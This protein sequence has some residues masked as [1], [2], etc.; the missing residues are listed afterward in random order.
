MTKLR[1]ITTAEP[2]AW[3]SALEAAGPH[4]FYHEAWYH[5]LAEERGE[6]RAELVVASADSHS[7]ALPILLRNIEPEHRGAFGPLEDATSVYGYPG[8]VGPPLDTDPAVLDRLAG[9]IRGYLVERGAVSVFSRLHPVIEQAALLRNPS[10][11]VEVGATASI[12]L[13]DS[14]EVQW[15]HIRAGHRNGINR[16]R[17][18]GFTCE[19]RGPAAIDTFIELYETTMRRLEVSSYYFFPRSH[20][21]AMLDPDRGNMELFVVTAPDGTPCA[22]G[23][24][25]LRGEIAQ[26]HLSGA[27]P[28]YRAQA[29]TVLM[30]DGARQWAAACG[31][32][33][34]HLGGGVGGATDSLYDFKA[35][36]GSGRHTFSVWNWIARPDIYGELDAMRRGR[37]PQPQTPYFPSYRAP[38]A[39][40]A[41]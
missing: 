23:L 3:A 37:G 35:G 16:L 6:G 28:D 12:D 9:A 38:L 39:S 17:R 31:A 20:Y 27:N 33:R 29:P 13:R 18:L 8:P 5:S 7:A 22:T 40:R 32:S 1:I 14:A 26:Y 2:N 10:E 34:L 36:F 41:T 24:F 25:S 11:V 4:D 21:E 15:S 30:L 19:Q